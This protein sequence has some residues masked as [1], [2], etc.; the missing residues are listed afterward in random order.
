M[1][2]FEES[3]ERVHAALYHKVA[4]DIEL[5]VNNGELVKGEK[6][7][8]E[9]E[10]AR[11][12]GVS[13]TTLR[14]ALRKLEEE[15]VIVRLHGIGTFVAQ[16]R[17]WAD[18]R[19]GAAHGSTVGVIL[20][21]VQDTFG[22]FLSAVSRVASGR[23][24]RVIVGYNV[25][26]GQ[27]ESFVDSF[28]EQGVR[29]LVVLPRGPS[30]YEVH[31]K[32][33]AAGIPIVGFAVPPMMGVDWVSLDDTG[34]ISAGVN[35]LVSQGHRMIGYVHNAAPNAQYF[36]GPER[37]SA[38][39]QAIAA[40]GMS[41]CQKWIIS[42][43]SHVM[44]EREIDAAK[45]ILLAEGRP[46]AFMCYNDTLATQLCD[47]ALDVGLDV[48][49]DLSI[50]GI[51]NSQEGAGNVVPL[52]SVDPGYGQMGALAMGLL[53]DRIEGDID[54]PPKFVKAEPGGLIVRKSTCSACVATGV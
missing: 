40:G 10:L 12:Y 28:I 9:R 42:V 32:A 49:Q 2:D 47:V 24:C 31:E 27:E 23:G 33:A 6:L 48:P 7:P 50:V 37:L 39:Q 34:L 4:W 5:K 52:T 16:D 35:Y 38:Y 29:G 51:D 3:V 15:R 18:L 54:A 41:A 14:K 11:M 53:L 22:G 44:N 46:T 36:S 21:D 45:E 1:A 19:K 30:V 25:T 26:D 17:D 43:G 13:R 8:D 20:R